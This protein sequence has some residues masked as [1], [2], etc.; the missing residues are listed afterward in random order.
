[1][2]G[3]FK[4]DKKMDFFTSIWET[5]LEYF[6][7]ILLEIYKLNE[8]LQAPDTKVRFKI[9]FRKILENFHMQ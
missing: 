6:I 1:M 2:K 9:L 5:I 4:V 3:L 7:K 8:K